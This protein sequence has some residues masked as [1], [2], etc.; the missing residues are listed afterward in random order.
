[1][2]HINDAVI[3][4][5]EARLRVLK[6]ELREAIDKQADNEEIARITTSVREYSG[7]LENLKKK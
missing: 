3:R 7:M 2:K 5:L 1:M 6:I 4:L